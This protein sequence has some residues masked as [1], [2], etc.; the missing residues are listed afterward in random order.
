[1]GIS[2]LLTV[3]L[4][5]ASVREQQAAAEGP[6]EALP[7]LWNRFQSTQRSIL[8]DA[9][10]SGDTINLQGYTD[11]VMGSF[12][13]PDDLSSFGLRTQTR[14]VPPATDQ[15]L[16]LAA[17]GVRTTFSRISPQKAPRA[18]FILGC[19]LKTSTR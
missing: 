16:H 2:D 19:V 8:K 17:D 6:Q 4:V 14:L 9:A 12:S 13:L 18:D 5:P 10:S 1:M 11:A 15:V 3:L 7:A